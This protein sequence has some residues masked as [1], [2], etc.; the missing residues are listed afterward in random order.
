MAEEIRSTRENCPS[1]SLLG[2]NRTWFGIFVTLG[3]QSL[4]LCN[5]TYACIRPAC[6]SLCKQKCQ[7]SHHFACLQR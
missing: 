5:K 3:K 1:A 2:T 7:L 4:M 6:V